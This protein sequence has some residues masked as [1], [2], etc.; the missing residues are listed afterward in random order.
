MLTALYRLHN[1]HKKGTYWLCV[2]DCGN[3]KE[4]RLMDLKYNKGKLCGWYIEKALKV[5]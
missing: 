2:C 4:V 5:N 1:Y 3:I